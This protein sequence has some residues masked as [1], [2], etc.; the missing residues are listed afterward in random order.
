MRQPTSPIL[1]KSVVSWLLYDISNTVFNFGV[2]GV[3]LSLWINQQPGTTD[4]DLG[5]PVRI[6]N[7]L[8]LIIS[9]FLGTLTD[10]LKGRVSIFT[11]L[12]I[13]A[14]LATFWIGFIENVKVGL[15]F[16]CVAYVC[17][18]LAE[19]LY[20][21]MLSDASTPDN[22]G[23]IG[24]L[25]I[26]IGYFGC[27]FLIYLGLKL[28]DVAPNYDLAFHV[29]GV[30]I[31]LA[32]LPITFFFSETTQYIS[33]T[34]KQ[35]FVSVRDQITGTISHFRDNPTLLKF[36]IARFFYMTAVL[37]SATFAVMY[38]TKTIQFSAREV[39]Y[40]FLFG[41]IFAI[42]GAYLWGLLSDR[43]GPSIALKANIGGWVFF[44]TGAVSI[45][46]F[47][48]DTNFWWPLGCIIGF[49]FGGL[50][51]TERPLL[52]KLTPNN[53][54]EMFGI[55]G[56]ISRLA[57]ILGTSVWINLAVTLDLGQVYAVFALLVFSIIGLLILIKYVR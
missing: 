39:Q 33:K 56:A 48:L 12:N 49:C 30:I 25:G 43:I 6:S 13:V 5:N 35:I 34:Q 32:T 2:V 53:L 52:I 31:L 29:I 27:L 11:I 24:G 45:P 21:A 3:F 47:G 9:P 8:V 38:G 20:N 50:W 28:E 46:A 57:T 41:S 42:P 18:Y 7:I 15:T 54:G 14:A 51:A 4:A 37:T 17:I 22:R 36:F 19:L 1:N 16:F 26:A 23:K 55:Y 44:L 10:Q 40:V